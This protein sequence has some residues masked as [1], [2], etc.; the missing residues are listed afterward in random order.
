MRLTEEDWSQMRRKHYE[1]YEAL[2]RLIGIEAL[3][4]LMPVDKETLKVAYDK[5]EHLNSIPLAEWDRRCPAVLNLR[6][7][8]RS[9]QKTFTWAPCNGVCVLKHVARHHV[10]EVPPP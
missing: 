9:G 1:E 5:D 10:L 8:A 3:K 7:R 4:R 6:R 2:A